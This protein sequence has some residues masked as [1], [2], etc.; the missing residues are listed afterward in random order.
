MPSHHISNRR[1][2]I[3]SRRNLNTN[4]HQRRTS[5]SAISQ[6]HQLRHVDITDSARTN[7]KHK[8]R[9]L[10]QERTARITKT[11]SASMSQKIKL[12][13]KKSDLLYKQL[14]QIK[15]E[16][17]AKNLNAMLQYWGQR[18][19][20][21]NTQNAFLRRTR[22]SRH[23]D[24]HWPTRFMVTTKSNRNID[25]IKKAVQSAFGIDNHPQAKKALSISTLFKNFK[26]KRYF[27]VELSCRR[28][29]TARDAN[30]IASALKTKCQFESVRIESTYFDL[31]MNPRVDGDS[32]PS[33]DTEWHLRKTRVKEAWAL[34][35]PPGGRQQGEGIVIGHP[36]SGWRPHPEYD[37]LSPYQNKIVT[38]RA[39][40]VFNGTIGPDAAIHETSPQWI[41]SNLTHGTATGS[42]MVSET[43]A[44]GS[45]WVEHLSE[46]LT[47]TN[48]NIQISGV[49]PRAQVLPIKCIESVAL[50]GDV[51][52]A[53]AIDYAANEGVDVISLSLGGTPYHALEDRIREAVTEENIIVIAAAGQINNIPD[54]ATSIYHN[55]VI[56]PAAYPEV[57]AVGGST[58][59][60]KPWADSFRGEKIDICA[61][62]FNVWFADFDEDGGQ[63]ITYGSGTSFSAAQVASIAALW[64]AFHGGKT[65]IA[66]AYPSRPVAE[67]F[68]HLLKQTAQQPRII[69]RS[70]PGTRFD[71][72]EPWN[73]T[74]FG[75]GIVN[76]EALLSAALPDED[77]VTLPLPQESNFV[78]W[79]Q[80][81][82]EK[83]EE[84]TAILSE[85]S[86]DVLAELEERVRESSEFAQ[87]FIETMGLAAIATAQKTAQELADKAEEALETTLALAESATNDTKQ[88]AEELAEDA[89]ETWEDT[90]ETV[91]EIAEEIGETVDE[92][93]DSTTD[94]VED[95]ADT[96]SETAE[97]IIDA[98][99]PPW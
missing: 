1:N 79:I 25:E 41:L 56:E 36:D 54:Y 18:A 76:A 15:S 33:Q 19:Q 67:V 65:A 94:V 82:L 48:A 17:K 14:G 39:Y 98:I 35:P 42:M 66:N 64:L 88:L 27:V 61:P 8:I 91:E 62:A 70:P 32:P 26:T 21:M 49:A 13:P 38:N 45:T 11:R 51:N 31:Q 78:S 83:G 59:D 85:L 5:V 37:E 44:A 12:S 10:N 92:L 24:A 74:L 30:N 84:A 93:I 77:D 6:M 34:T 97:T 46:P 60:D 75:A 40:N 95:L 99:T 52:V 50:L 53:R 86:E 3:R 43:A 57:I 90:K 89:A 96:G 47:G 29:E 22:H 20:Q 7:A 55:T 80:D 87:D 81:S 72:N 28:G 73:E 63:K 4:S 2:N 58:I 16:I 68:R 69:D 9:L 71:I 23:K